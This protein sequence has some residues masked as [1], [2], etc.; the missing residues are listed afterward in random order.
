MQCLDFE[1]WLEDDLEVLK[2]ISVP[3]Q[4]LQYLDGI[5]LDFRHG[6]GPVHFSRGQ[7]CNKC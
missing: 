5:R 1:N 7:A 2:K 4:V 6:S 3:I